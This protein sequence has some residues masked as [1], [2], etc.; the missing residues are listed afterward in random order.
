MVKRKLDNEPL[1]L[2]PD[3]PKFFSIIFVLFIFG[4]LINSLF[5][6]FFPDKFDTNYLA[7]APSNS[8]KRA[9]TIPTNTTAVFE[10]SEFSA[11]SS[12]VISFQGEVDNTPI[13]EIYVHSDLTPSTKLDNSRLNYFNNNQNQV[14]DKLIVNFHQNDV[15]RS[16]DGCIVTTELTSDDELLPCSKAAIVAEIKSM[17]NTDAEAT[18]NLSDND[19][20][21]SQPLFGDIADS[22]VNEDIIQ[23]SP[24]NN[25]DLGSYPEIL[26]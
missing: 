22:L 13:P 15:G 10:Y 11:P 16:I 24:I 2:G 5:S 12:E 20:F 7:S 6:F 8:S 18:Q 25:D 23:D 1:N 26:N 17:R 19:N 4:L 9:V 14:Y 3:Y 21:M